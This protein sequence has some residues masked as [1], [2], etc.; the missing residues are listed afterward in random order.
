MFNWVSNQ[1]KNYWKDR[2]KLKGN[3]KEYKLAIKSLEA[4][5]EHN[6]SNGYLSDDDAEAQYYALKSRLDIKNELLVNAKEALKKLDEF[7]KLQ[8]YK[9]P[10]GSGANKRGRGKAKK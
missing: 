10:K 3:I 4:L 7:G 6:L 9:K 1:E 2:E 5:I 8:G